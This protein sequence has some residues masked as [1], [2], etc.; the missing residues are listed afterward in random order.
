VQLCLA[1]SDLAM[2]MPEWANVVG[3]M[4]DRYG[5]D[6]GTVPVLLGFL[7]CLVEEA[8]NPRIPLSVSR[9]QRWCISAHTRLGR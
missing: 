2:Q 5:K 9:V 8:G 1:L 6:P 7:K 4:V 3:G